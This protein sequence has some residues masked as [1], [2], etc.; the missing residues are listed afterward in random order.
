MWMRM[1]RRFIPNHDIDNLLNT[2][3]QAFSLTIPTD[4]QLTRYNS[5]TSLHEHFPPGSAP[6]LPTLQRSFRDGFE[7]V[8]HGMQDR[9]PTIAR[10]ADSLSA[11]WH[12]S[13]EASLHFCPPTSS[14]KH[15][16]HP[17]A[18]TLRNGDLFVVVLD[19]ELVA[20][21]H[22]AVHE[23]P[24]PSETGYNSHSILSS[25]ENSSPKSISLDEGD[26]LYVPRGSASCVVARNSAAL[27]LAFH[28]RTDEVPA[29][30][31]LRAMLMAAQKRSD[32][33][34]GKF[35]ASQLYWSDIV[36]YA[37]RVAHD[38]V[39]PLRRFFPLSGPIIEALED[40]GKPVGQEMAIDV[41]QKFVISAVNAFFDPFIE[42]IS[43]GEVNV[44]D[45]LLRWARQVSSEKRESAS[46]RQAKEMFKVCVDWLG[47][48]NDA[49]NDGV[50][51]L[52]LEWMTQLKIRRETEL[53]QRDDAFQAQ[54]IKEDLTDDD[55]ICSE[56]DDF[57]VLASTA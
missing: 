27:Y 17:R 20:N 51:Q 13:V 32:G 24:L 14:T 16:K 6:V 3:S 46:Y 34:L 1:H 37:I 52:T 2:T 45:S 21:V 31:A 36:D 41:L 50:S 47:R 9:S 43:E 49:P 26:V 38:V 40:A 12:V 53:Q 55:L 4:L 57:C 18:A 22:E 44:E 25:L 54:R 5:S 11:F 35:A 7:L 15:A 10:F 33:P 39:P 56:E 23:F 29:T 42:A 30:M 48:Q 19:G 8:L 28:I